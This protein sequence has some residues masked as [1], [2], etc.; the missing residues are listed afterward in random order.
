M[1]PNQV[2]PLEKTLGRICASGTRAFARDRKALNRLKAPALGQDEAVR[3]LRAYWSKLGIWPLGETGVYLLGMAER[4]SGASR[5]DC[6][7][8]AGPDPSL[9]GRR[10]C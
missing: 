9:A 6:E 8:L 7:S 5:K 10:V 1:T 4:G 2:E 3:K